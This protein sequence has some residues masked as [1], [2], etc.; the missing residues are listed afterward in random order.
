MRVLRLLFASDGTA[1]TS[2]WHSE[3]VQVTSSDPTLER[4]DLL[5]TIL[6]CPIK[7]T[8]KATSSPSFLV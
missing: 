7:V 3:T 5:N 1:E 8:V 4:S 2:T 6:L